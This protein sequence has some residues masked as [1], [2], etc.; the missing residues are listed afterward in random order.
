MNIGYREEVGGGFCE[1]CEAG[2]KSSGHVVTSVKI[3]NL[4]YGGGKQ[5]TLNEEDAGWED[6]SLGKNLKL[7]V[8]SNNGGSA[9]FLYEENIRRNMKRG[10]DYVP[11]VCTCLCW[12]FVIQLV[13]ESPTQ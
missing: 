6:V 4:A 5:R 10:W 2:E 8:V 7:R 1:D 11:C 9:L 3:Q 13:Y 12:H